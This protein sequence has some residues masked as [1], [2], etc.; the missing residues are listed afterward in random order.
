MKY[1]V[2]FKMDRGTYY[3]TEWFDTLEEARTF[4]FYAGQSGVKARYI[5]DSDD[6]IVS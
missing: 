1:R 2:N 6:E 5:V 3:Y 4:S